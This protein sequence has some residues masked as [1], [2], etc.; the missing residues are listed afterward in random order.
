MERGP[1]PQSEHH[2]D[3]LLGVAAVS[4]SDVWAV[5]YYDN[6]PSCCPDAGRALERQRMECRPQPQRGHAHNY[7]YGVA[8]VSA[9]DV[10]AVGY[11]FNGSAR[12]TLVEH[13]NGSAWSVV[14]SAQC[15]HHQRALWSSS[16]LCHRCVGCGLLLQR[17]CM[18][19]T[20]VEHWDG[21][22]WSVVPSPNL[23]T[24]DNELNGVAA[25]SASDVWAVGYYYERHAR[26]D[27]G[28]AL[29]RQRLERGPQAPMW[30]P[31][32]ALY[33][34]AAV[35]ANDVWAVG[36]CPM[37]ARAQTLVEHWNGSAWSVVPSPNV[38]TTDND[39][40]GVAAVSASDVWAVGYASMILPDASRAI[41]PLP[42]H[43][44]T[45]SLVYSL[46]DSHSLLA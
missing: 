31:H 38:G 28:G 39:L 26:P 12:Q 3:F 5:G 13:W 11:Y 35:S 16:Y 14:T 7:L 21:S 18:S 19:Q 44:H 6:G 23:G 1:Q 41:Q 42:A 46:V 36:Y 33:G 27:A 32:N 2:D 8:A 30:A 15:G 25:V 10:W 37:A 29:E 40:N 43:T 22:S 20:L 17:H 4:A 9:T 45:Y 24:T 34:V